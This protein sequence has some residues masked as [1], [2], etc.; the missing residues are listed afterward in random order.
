MST[1]APGATLPREDVCGV[2][3]LS[4]FDAI[5]VVLLRYVTRPN[6][7]GDKRASPIDVVRNLNPLEGLMLQ[8]RASPLAAEPSNLWA[9]FHC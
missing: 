9:R 6:G 3:Y 8:D 2:G 5:G 4:S 1:D 7:S